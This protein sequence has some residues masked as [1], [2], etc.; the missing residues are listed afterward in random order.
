MSSH[1]T[2]VYDACVLYPAP[3]RDFLM[4]LA[5][6]DLFRARWTNMIHEEWI[7]NVLARRPDIEPAALERTRS[8]MNAHVRDCLVSGFEHLIPSIELPDPDDRHVVA[9]A[10]H[11]GSSLIVTF[12]LKDFPESHLLRY[13]IVAQHPDDFIFSLI[14]LHPA[15]VCEAAASHRRSLKYPPKAADEYLDALLRQGLAQTVGRLREWKMAI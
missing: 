7:R 9:A 10:I 13:N 6:T 1:F 15:Q 2:V 5:L 4:R 3:L 14:D 11:S 12:N 8:L